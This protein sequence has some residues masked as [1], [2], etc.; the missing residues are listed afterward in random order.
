MQWWFPERAS[1]SQAR[2]FPAHTHFV[3]S[4]ETEQV[5]HTKLSHP[6]F[7]TA[8]N[9][10]KGRTKAHV[11]GSH[12]DKYYILSFRSSDC[13]LNVFPL[14]RSLPTTIVWTPLSR[15]HFLLTINSLSCKVKCEVAGFRCLQRHCM[16][17]SY[18]ECCW[19]LQT[20][21]Y[22]RG[23]TVKTGSPAC[24][25]IYFCNLLLKEIFH[26]TT[27]DECAWCL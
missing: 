1:C 17:Q 4:C 25:H 15:F 10:G 24:L 23:Q 27:K 20:K 26:S 21:R 8:S 5:T 2:H 12:S 7:L 9:R 18:S 19:C 11:P 16:K 14:D 13:F 3:H 22:P 6:L